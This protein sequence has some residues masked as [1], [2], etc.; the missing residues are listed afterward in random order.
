MGAAM[1]PSR[2][3][4]LIPLYHRRRCDSKLSFLLVLACAVLFIAQG[5]ATMSEEAF[6]SIVPEQGHNPSTDNNRVARIMDDEELI[7]NKVD[8]VEEGVMDASLLSEKDKASLR[9]HNDRK[10][11]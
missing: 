11:L 8:L 7:S 2:F 5:T 3:H 6:D 10:A 9:Y 4:A 1:K